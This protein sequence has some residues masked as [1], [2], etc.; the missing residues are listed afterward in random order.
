MLVALHGGHRV[1]VEPLGSRSVPPALCLNRLDSFRAARGNDTR[2]QSL[3]RGREEEDKEEHEVQNSYNGPLEMID[4]LEE[5]L[6][7]R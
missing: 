3:G 4:A 6:P 1:K 5:V 2:N 7:M